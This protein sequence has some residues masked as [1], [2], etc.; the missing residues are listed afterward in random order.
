MTLLSKVE[1]EGGRIPFVHLKT[2]FVM[3]NSFTRILGQSTRLYL[4]LPRD[5]Q[6]DY[7]KLCSAERPH[8]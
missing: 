8:K 2:T 7:S 3:W 6:Q 4:L 5:A 1:Q